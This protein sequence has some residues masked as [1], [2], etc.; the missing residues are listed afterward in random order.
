MMKKLAA[1]ALLLAFTL[2]LS[3]Q[4]WSL[5]VSTGPFVFGDFL[6]RTVQVGSGGTQGTQVII[7]SA[8]TRAG[9][10]V[11]L[12]RSFSER[13]AVRGEGTFTR[14]PM[15][16]SQEGTV[17]EFEID[18]GDLDVATFAL[19]LVFRI[20]P[21]GSF[22]FYLLGGPALAVYRLD[23]PA[24]TEPVIDE[25]QQEWGVAFGG[26]VAWWLSDRF[27]IEAKITDTITTSPMDEEDF[28]DTPG[29]NVKNPHNG[30]GTVG[31][32][33]RF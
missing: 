31:I 32:R 5:G 21:R 22:R 16:I 3:A 6:E 10:A 23:A 20:N 24:N 28:D 12:E 9:L 30:H 1:A 18:A 33:W 15:T 13:W 2:P 27:A 26:G 7:V 17:G 8:D 19:P 14:S 4:D 25:T 29:A 11:D